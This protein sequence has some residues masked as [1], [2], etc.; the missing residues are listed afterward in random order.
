MSSTGISHIINRVVNDDLGPECPPIEDPDFVLFGE[1]NTRQTAWMSFFNRVKLLE[2]NDRIGYMC[3]M[4]YSTKLEPNKF[5]LFYKIYRNPSLPEPSKELFL[6]IIQRSQRTYNGFSR[7]ARIWLCRRSALQIETDLF[8]SPLDPKD[9]RTFP[10]YDNNRNLYYFSLVDLTRIITESLTYSYL[11]FSEPKICK[12]PY[13]NLPFSKSTLYNI[14]FQMKDAF[15][16]VPKFIQLFFEA[17]FNVYHFKLQNENLL[18][19]T[20]VLNMI[21]QSSSAVLEADI[22]KM[23]LYCDPYRRVRIH[24]DYPREDLIRHMKPFLR[25][26]WLKNH[27][28]D[29][30]RRQYYANQLQHFFGNFIRVNPH[31]GRKLERPATFMSTETS[32]YFMECKPYPSKISTNFLE[33]HKYNEATYNRYTYN[34]DEEPEDV[35]VSVFILATNQWVSNPAHSLDLL[36]NVASHLQGPVED[37]IVEENEYDDDEDEDEDEEENENATVVHEESDTDS[38]PEW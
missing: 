31:F 36:S 6:Q 32:Y 11:F 29:T 1:S 22:R 28:Y 16:K 38:E 19:E 33:D 3:S 25:L 23:I 12:N 21:E 17:D 15:Y 13:T 4:F 20:I 5:R 10:L 26:F 30:V 37:N 35:P 8:M 24:A 2:L 18:R 14:Y 7:L 27:T 9:K 34:I